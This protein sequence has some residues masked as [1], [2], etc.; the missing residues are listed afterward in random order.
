MTDRSIPGLRMR[1]KALVGRKNRI[2]ARIAT[3]MK[4][5]APDSAQLRSLKQ[6]RLRVKD[7]AVA[8]GRR[9]KSRGPTE[10]SAA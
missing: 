3:E 2:E 5:P 6:L 8:I 1:L 10:P 4:R 7:E 9:L